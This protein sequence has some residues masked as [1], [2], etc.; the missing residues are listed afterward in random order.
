VLPGSLDVPRATRWDI[1]L[2]R[3]SSS[4]W[5][6][7]VR[8]HERYGTHELLV[9]PLSSGPVGQLTLTSSGT[10]TSRSL[11][12][13][14][15]VRD[16][17][18]GREVYVSYA[19]SASRGDLNSL[20]SLSGVFREAFV[21]PNA[22]AVLPADVPHR[23]L[24]WGIV[25]LPGQF[26]VSPFVEV[27]SG[28]PFSAVNDDWTFADPRNGY[29]FPW[30]GSLDLYVNRVVGLPGRLPDARLGLKAY[31][32]LSIHSERDVQRDIA[33][34]DFGAL[35]NRNPRDFTFVFEL[36]WGRDH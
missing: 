11:E 30:Y 19:R 14:A 27:R 13:T 24:T 1:A 2:D 32:L 5:L 25:K 12:A 8:Y 34:A 6:V 15:G 29:R 16:P 23:L 9:N 33:R 21:Q 22:R 26:V 10:S 36:L 7:R 28:F 3:Q 4:P 31:N 20:E 35:Y 18:S 17:D